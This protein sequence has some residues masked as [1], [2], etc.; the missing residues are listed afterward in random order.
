MYSNDNVDMQKEMAFEL[1][2]ER[3]HIPEGY[4]LKSHLL[5]NHDVIPVFVFRFEKENGQNNGLG[6][7]HYSVSVD[8]D[9]TKIM[10]FM[11]VDKQ[12]CGQGLPHDEIAKEIA[13]PF[14]EAI[15]P[16]LINKFEIKWV[17]PLKEK[18]LKI[19]HESPFPFID[20]N[21]MQHLITGVRVKLF[22]EH[23]KSWGWVIVGRDNKIIA[24]E[25]EVQWST[26]LNRRSTPAWLHD[27]F[28]LDLKDDIQQKCNVL[29]KLGAKPQKTNRIV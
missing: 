10:G 8:L 19:P 21:G 2:N 14:V 20:E 5:V 24:F 11:H 25:R 28:L 1:I 13:A 18:P 6:G 23:L 16:D 26:I 3:L 9:A 27:P 29:D 7:E 12:H 17:L 4:V 15:A 22:F